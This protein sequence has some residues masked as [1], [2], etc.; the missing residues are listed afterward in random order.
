MSV[1]AGLNIKRSMA[2]VTVVRGEKPSADYA[3]QMSLERGELRY[4]GA[5]L[6]RGNRVFNG[7][8]GH[9]LCSFARTAHCS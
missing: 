9:S 8:L 7:P 5:F 6:V 2:T 4:E 3:M 1:A